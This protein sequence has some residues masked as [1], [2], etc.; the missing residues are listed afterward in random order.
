MKSERRHELQESDLVHALESGKAVFEEH[1][2]TIGIVVLVAAALVVVTN[3]VSGA[4]EADST[5]QF[6]QLSL[7]AFNT[8]E[9]KSESFQKLMALS[10]E[11]STDSLAVR[12]LSLRGARALESAT[13]NASVNQEMN[14]LARESFSR[15]LKQH[16]SNPVAEGIARLGIATC[17]ENAFVLDGDASHK[18]LALENIEAIIANEKMHTLPFYAMALERKEKIDQTFSTVE[19]VPAPVEETA[20]ADAGTGNT[21]ITITPTGDADS[22]LPITT[23]V[24]DAVPVGNPPFGDADPAGGTDDAAGSDDGEQAEEPG[25]ESADD[26]R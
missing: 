13:E 22:A 23:K 14:E 12:T 4:R 8:E 18:T 7:L 6:Q 10:Q 21:G 15:L 9:E 2:K 24:I 1:G 5:R 25:S 16:G 17:E 19:F 3:V 26:G 20:E 11:A